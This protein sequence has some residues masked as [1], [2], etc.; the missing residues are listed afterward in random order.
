MDNNYN[1]HNS[2]TIMVLQHISVEPNLNC[3]TV[4]D[5]TG[6]HFLKLGDN[7]LKISCKIEYL[8]K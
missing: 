4:L 1:A 6:I 7:K 8:I 2:L 3:K 5:D